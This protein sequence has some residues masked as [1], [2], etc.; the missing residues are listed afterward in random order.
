MQ[1][2]VLEKINAVLHD[3]RSFFMGPGMHDSF[4]MSLQE[5]KVI[6]QQSGLYLL[7]HRTNT[8]D[9]AWHGTPYLFFRHPWQSQIHHPI[10]LSHHSLRAVPCFS[11]LLT[12][13]CVG[14]WDPALGEIPALDPKRV[15]PQSSWRAEIC[16]SFMK[17]SSS[18]S[19]LSHQEKRE[20]WGG[21][22]S[23]NLCWGINWAFRWAERPWIWKDEKKKKSKRKEE[24]F[25]SIR[26][27]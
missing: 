3:D 7:S 2:L 6:C 12:P 26:M 11:Q 23:F 24:M 14:E 8:S 15:S 17:A 18:E 25:S 20:L 1:P 9:P 10:A 5:E 13:T 22:S 16:L 19:P 21:R 27:W 4:L